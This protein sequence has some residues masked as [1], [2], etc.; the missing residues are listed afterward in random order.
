[1]TA[2]PPAPTFASTQEPYGILITGVGGTGIVTLGALIGMAAHIDG[3]GVTVLDMTGLAQKGGAVLSHVRICDDPQAIHAVRIATG[4]ADAVIG[5]DIVV[6]ASNDALSRMHAGRTRVAVNCAETPTAE[7]TRNPQWQF[8]QAKLREA[9][10]GSVGAASAHF[11]DATDLARRLLGDAIAGNL[12]LLGYAWQL[13]LVPVSAAAL[14]RSIELNG[15]AVAM[16]RSAFL[17]GRLAAHDPSAVAAPGGGTASADAVL[18]A[19]TFESSYDQRLRYLADYQDDAYAERYRQVVERFRTEGPPELADAV[20]RNLFKL[21]AIKDEYEVARLFAAPEFRRQLDEAFEG[22]WT[23]RFHLAPTLLAHP[24]PTTGRVRKIDF[25]SWLWP[26]L[27]W[28][29]RRKHWRNTFWDVF[30]F[31]DDRRLDRQELADYLADLA[32][33][34]FPLAPEELQ[35]AVKLAQLPE[36][37]RG[38]GPVRRRSVEAAAPERARLR[39]LLF[40][41]T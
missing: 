24:D 13:G 7:F 16:N 11:I 23:L 5:G 12:F 39:R 22:A 17:W 27:R 32:A 38:F 36:S 20:M 14:D 40:P 37:V 31:G 30:R 3:K 6:A 35:A 21:M 41:D 28:L 2:V 29:A 8:P 15:T 34:R 4:E 26:V 9:I 1:M 25:G 10:S 19:P 18:P 33:I